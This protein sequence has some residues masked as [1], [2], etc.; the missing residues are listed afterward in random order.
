MGAWYEKRQEKEKRPNIEKGGGT[1]PRGKIQAFMEGDEKNPPRRIRVEHRGRGQRG[2]KRVQFPEK[3]KN[4]CQRTQG[5]GKTH[6]VRW[7]RRK[8]GSPVNRKDA[9]A[10]GGGERSDL[11]ANQLSEPKKKQGSSKRK[12]KKGKK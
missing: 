2:E 9:V 10:A 1:S 11:V 8:M 6:R 12:N 7:T 3:T 4:P 5:G